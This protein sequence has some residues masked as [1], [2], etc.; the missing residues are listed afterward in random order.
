MG[1]SAGRV[2]V[3]AW[4]PGG[5]EGGGA[6]VGGAADT[7]CDRSRRDALIGAS[8]LSRAVEVGRVATIDC[9]VP[10]WVVMVSS[11]RVMDASA[12]RAE[13]D[14]GTRIVSPSE[15]SASCRSSRIG[16]WMEEKLSLWRV[17]RTKSRMQRWDSVSSA[18]ED[19][20]E[21]AGDGAPEEGRGGSSS[22]VR[23]R[24]EGREA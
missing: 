8:Q 19:C 10:N 16:S 4:G 18:D 13:Q 14:R 15:S 2:V 20:L 5:R 3:P 1:A 11:G 23:T 12:L 22:I 7:L 9:M 17:S 6:W 24:H 21:G